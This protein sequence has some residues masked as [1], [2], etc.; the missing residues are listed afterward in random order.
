LGKPDLLVLDEPSNGVDQKSQDE[1]YRLIKEIN[2]ID[3]VA[4]ISVEHNLKAAMENSTFLYHLCGGTGH[5]CSPQE[6][7][8]EYLTANTGSGAHASV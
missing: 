5:L 6:Y 7:L 3:Q 1:I 2:S 4:V 8:N